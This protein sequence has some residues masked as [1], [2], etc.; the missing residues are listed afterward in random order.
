[1]LR[2]WV[3]AHVHG[4]V[5]TDEFIAYASDQTGHDLAELCDSWLMQKGLPYLPRE[6]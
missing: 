1:M 3:A 6:R 5:T 4:T 2:G